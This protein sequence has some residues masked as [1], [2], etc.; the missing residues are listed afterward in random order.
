MRF[1]KKS[2]PTEGQADKK[3]AS[4]V[5]PGQNEPQLDHP[6]TRKRQTKAQEKKNASIKKKGPDGKKGSK[7]SSKAPN[8]KDKDEEEDDSNE[9]DDAQRQKG[10]K[11]TQRKPPK[12]K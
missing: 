9:S 5:L 1:S 11:D 8:P 6:E 4:K 3:Q 2:K 12:K 7:S 10:R